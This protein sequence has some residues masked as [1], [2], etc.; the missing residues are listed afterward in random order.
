MRQSSPDISSSLR[1]FIRLSYLDSG[2][3]SS[4]NNFKHFFD[5][6]VFLKKAVVDCCWHMGPLLFWL[7]CVFVIFSSTMS[8]HGCC[9]KRTAACSERVFLSVFNTFIAVHLLI[10][11]VK[12]WPHFAPPLMEFSC[13]T[14]FDWILAF[15]VFYLYMCFVQICVV[16]SKHGKQCWLPTH[17][18]S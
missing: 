16:F 17:I 14:F 1:R 9:F 4:A 3:F 2:I 13:L 11:V 12:P 6:L 5:G 7:G 18:T 10:F 15:S 8:N